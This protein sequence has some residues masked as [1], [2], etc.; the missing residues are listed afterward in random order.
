MQHVFFA[1][2][3]MKIYFQFPIVSKKIKPTKQYFCNAVNYLLHIH[4]KHLGFKDMYKSVKYLSCFI[5]TQFLT[6]SI[7]V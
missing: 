7:S 5:L 4:S 6:I 3:Q 1:N 2:Q